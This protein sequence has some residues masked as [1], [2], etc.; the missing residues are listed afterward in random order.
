M[1]KFQDETFTT[2]V[3]NSR[4]TGKLLCPLPVVAL[5]KND[6]VTSSCFPTDKSE[7]VS[8]SPFLPLKYAV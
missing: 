4:H 3:V 2:V 5:H 7:T 6:L 1:I 8:C